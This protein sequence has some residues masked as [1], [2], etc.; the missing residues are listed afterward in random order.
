MMTVIALGIS[1]SIASTAGWTSSQTAEP[2][3]FYM[4][5]LEVLA[6][7][8]TLDDV[9]PYYT[10]EMRDGLSKMPDEMKANYLKM[11]RRGLKDLKVTSQKIGAGQAVF[12]MT[13][14]GP[15]GQPAS[16]K[17]TLVKEGTAWKIDDDAWAMSLK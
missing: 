10:K 12:E 17:V 11:N 9:L 2:L 14:V 7:A 6:K 16:G 4:K 3:P 8:K 1:L 5:Y 15:A 13:A